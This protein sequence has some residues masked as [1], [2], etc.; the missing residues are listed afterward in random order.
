M[1]EQTCNFNIKNN[2]K[3]F[4]TFLSKWIGSSNLK[5][6]A[7]HFQIEWAQSSSKNS[8]TFDTT[9]ELKSL[10]ENGTSFVGKDRHEKVPILVENKLMEKLPKENQ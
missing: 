8:E 10:I 7:I 2:D 4:N 5:K 9:V 3:I 6:T 1:E